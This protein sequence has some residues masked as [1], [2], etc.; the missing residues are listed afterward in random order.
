MATSGTVN[1]NN[2]DGV[3]GSYLSWQIYGITP[4]YNI[5]TLAWQVGWRF[6]ATS[7]RGLRL[8]GASIAGV[9]IYNN[10]SGGDGVH[11]Y[12]SSHNHKPRLQVASGTFNIWH[13]GAN[14]ATFTAWV[15]MTG[16][17]GLHSVGSASFTVPAISQPTPP[18]THP[19]RINVG[20]SW[21]EASPYVKMGG[22]WRQATPYV[23]MGGVWKGTS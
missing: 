16:W 2:V 6:S 7:C 21:K 15:E 1:G 18:Q 17:S 23:R 3:E 11:S 12:N 19:V 20:G 14:P 9:T 22:V 4:E 10:R 8:G 13:S 5:T